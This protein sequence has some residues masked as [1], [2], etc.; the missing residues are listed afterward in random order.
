MKR[1]RGF[2]LIELLVVIAIV[3]VLIGLLL[4][5]VQ[6]ARESARRTQCKAH[7]QQIGLAMTQYLDAKGERGK[8]PAAAKLPKTLNPLNLPA[9]Y[10]VLGPYCENNREIFICP[11]DY[12]DPDTTETTDNDAFFTYHEREGLSY[13]YPSLML[14]GKTR[15]E[16]LDSRIGQLGSGRVWIVYDLNSFHGKSGQ[17]GSRNYVYLDGHVDAVVLPEGS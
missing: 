13:E 1:S 15:P 17:D 4:P 10:E 12:F 14:A 8:F 5:A 16:V 2:T 11:S 3:G 9:L 7:L 6:A